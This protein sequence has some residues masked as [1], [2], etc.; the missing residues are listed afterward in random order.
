VRYNGSSPGQTRYLGPR[1]TNRRYSEIKFNYVAMF[2]AQPT[3]A[4][5]HSLLQR[6]LAHRIP[7]VVL[8]DVGGHTTHSL[9]DQLARAITG[10]NLAGRIHVLQCTVRVGQENQF[11]AMI[12]GAPQNS[13]RVGLPEL[14]AGNQL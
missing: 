11:L 8:R 5:K 6:L 13:K 14:T 12:D 7:G 2:A 9:V 1:I 4:A 3:G 10:H